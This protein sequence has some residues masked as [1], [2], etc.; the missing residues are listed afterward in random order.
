MFVHATNN[1]LATFDS[2][3]SDATGARV[4]SDADNQK[5]ILFTNAGGC[6]VTVPASL[7]GGFS[8]TLVQ[9]SAGAVTLVAGAGLTFLASAAVVAPYTTFDQGSAMGVLKI[10]ATRALIFGNIG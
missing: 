10:S 1:G 6:S 2:I 7:S 9:D 4:L 5:V 8:V 3:E